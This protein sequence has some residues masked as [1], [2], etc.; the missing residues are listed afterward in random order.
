MNIPIFAAFEPV[1]HHPFQFPVWK[2]DFTGFG[3]AVVVSFII[4]QMVSESMMRLRGE[5]PD[6]I[7]DMILGAV[8]GGLVGAKAYF[9]VVL[10]NWDAL[11]SRGGFVFWGG[12]IGGAI[13]VLVIARFKKVSLW[14]TM[15]VGA[16]AVA[17]AYAVGRTGCWAVGDDYGRPWSGPLAVQFP[18]GAPA[19]TVGVMRSEFGVRFPDGMDP[20]TVVAVHPTQIYEVTMGLVMF[21]ILWRMRHH[22]HA[23]GWL[24]GVYCILAGIERFIVEFFRAKDDTLA[25]GITMAQSIA[26]VAVL[27]GVTLMVTRRRSSVA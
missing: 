14:T 20:S 26:I 9:V 10:G 8:I 6:P 16:P 21:F 1:V 3:I 24:F 2:L 11:W 23:A 22:K 27:L 4:A 5:N 13:G 12:L 25:I 18:Q 17:A 15:E 7:G 19:S